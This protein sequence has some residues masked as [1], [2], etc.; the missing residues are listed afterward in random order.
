MSGYVKHFENG[1]RNMSFVN[2][3]DSVLFKYNEIWNKIK[4]TLNTKFHTMPVYNEKYIKAKIRK[5]NV[6]IKTNFW[7][8]K[9]SK[10]DLYHTW[11]SCITIDS[12]MVMEKKII[13][14]FI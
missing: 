13:H 1:G 11:M 8:N 4:E 7:G 10:K 2:K 12:V 6:V 3:D 14:K 9:I 5:H